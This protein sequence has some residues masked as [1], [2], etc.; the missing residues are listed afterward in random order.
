MA[1]RKRTTVRV[2]TDEAV[3]HPKY[4][5][6]GPYAV[7]V[8]LWVVAGAPAFAVRDGAHLERRSSCRDPQGRTRSPAPKFCI[9]RW[10]RPGRWT[11]L[12]GAGLSRKR[13]TLLVVESQWQHW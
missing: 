12:A 8:G 9:M 1:F 2:G 5:C 4:L 10:W 11:H 13:G 3:I 7:I 6:L